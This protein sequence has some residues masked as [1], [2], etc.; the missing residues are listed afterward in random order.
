MDKSEGTV[1]EKLQRA[2]ALIKAGDKQG[3]QNLLVE[4]LAIDP[5][6]EQAWLWMATVTTGDKRRYCLEKAVR[7]NPNAPVQGE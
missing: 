4:V 3:G 2:A 1:A 7:I 6:N 5:R